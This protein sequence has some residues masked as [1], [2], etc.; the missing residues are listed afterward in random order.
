MSNGLTLLEEAVLQ[1][2]LA[3]DHP[4]LKKLRR[5]LEHCHASRREVSGAGFYTT[6]EVSDAVEAIPD[7]CLRFGDVIAQ[8]DGL[9]HGAGFLLYVEHGRIKMLEGYSYDEVWPGS[10]AGFRLEYSS[11]EGRDWLSLR[12]A[13]L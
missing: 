10:I 5:Q 4:I 7:S 3:G 2:L 6:I 9:H 11:G 12:K 13:G 1:M 8:I